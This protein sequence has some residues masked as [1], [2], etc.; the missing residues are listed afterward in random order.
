MSYGNNA[1]K[2]PWLT[3]YVRGFFLPK[4]RARLLLKA[5]SSSWR[6]RCCW[7]RYKEHLPGPAT[8]KVNTGHG[9]EKERTCRARLE[10]LIVAWPSS[11][12]LDLIL[13]GVYV[14]IA[15]IHRQQFARHILVSFDQFMTKYINRVLVNVHRD[16]SLTTHG[17]RSRQCQPAV[18]DKYD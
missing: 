7:E 14:P 8:T 18:R 10:T 16:S 11:W 15:V 3:R 4:S 9:N 6:R 12:M 1:C 5:R 2:R 13:R 17:D